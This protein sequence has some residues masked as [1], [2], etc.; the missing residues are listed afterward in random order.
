MAMK[1]ALF[2][3]YIPIFLLLPL[4]ERT[5]FHN[6]LGG[7][8]MSES[9]EDCSM[10]RTQELLSYFDQVFGGMSPTLARYFEGSEL[11]NFKDSARSNFET[12]IPKMPYLGE[13]ED[14]HEGNMLACVQMLSLIRVME[15]QGMEEREIGK[16][17]YECFEGAFSNMPDPY[18]EGFRSS[19]FTEETMDM[20]RNASQLSQVREFPEGWVFEVV[21][22]DQQKF[23]YGINYLECAV[24]KLFK[25]LGAERYMPYICLGDY[26]MFG[27]F[28]VG[29]CR[30]RTIGNGGDL[31]DFRF[32]E[33]GKTPS[34][35]PPDDLEEFRG[36]IE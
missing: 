23:D 31:C 5:H 14:I 21:D 11:D 22:G 30:T 28:G 25:K 1:S 17:V 34:G 15:E 12:L 32:K 24:F 29:L 16:I 8:W 7:R 6:R 19:F 18:K 26:A 4:W 33:N 2:I 20:W 36:T 13:G 3:S 27:A 35:W 9:E 10:D